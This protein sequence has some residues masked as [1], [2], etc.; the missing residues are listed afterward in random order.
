MSFAINPPNERLVDDRGN[1]MPS[2][3]RFFAS[4]QRVVGDGASPIDAGEF[5]TLSASSGLGSE[6]IFTP[7]AGQLTGVDAGAGGAYTLGLAN[8]AVVAGSYGSAS[9]TVSLTID[10][11]GRITAASESSGSALTKVDDTNV[12]LTLGGTPA[13]ALLAAT[14]LTLGWTGTLA[15][16]RGGTGAGSITAN[17]LVKGNGT[18][19]FSASNLSDDGNVVSVAS[20]KGFSVART[21]VTSPVANDGN[22]YSGTYTPTTTDVTNLDSSSAAT[23]QYM[24]VGDVVTVSGQV[25]VDPT[26]TGLVQ[27]GISLPVASNF[28]ANEQLG[29]VGQSSAVNGQSAAIRADTTNDRA[30]LAWITTDT[31]SRTMAFTFTYLVV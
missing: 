18:S 3:Y 11:K 20:G 4:I 1:V 29:G 7:T 16:S 30:Q 23:A 15:V 22:V 27:L 24:R 14:S 31:A 10:A 21:A 2:W 12:T 8:T 9:K 17:S 6:R 19:A 13:T 25:T 26:A 28:S 5:L